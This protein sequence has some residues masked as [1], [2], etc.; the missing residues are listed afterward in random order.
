MNIYIIAGPPGV[1]K[2][3][4]GRELIPAEIPIVDHDLAAYQYKK[5]G[6]EDYS[7][8]ASTKANQFIQEH[9]ANKLDFALELNLGYQ[10]HYDYLESLVLSDKK[11]KVHLILFF[12]DD[13]NLCLLRAEVRYKNG[14]H[15]VTSSVINEMYRNTLPLFKNNTQL[16]SSIS[17]VSVSSTDIEEVTNI[18][19]PPWV[20]LNGLS[21]YMNFRNQ[22]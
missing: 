16:F 2:S 11:V 17:F 7:Q 9:I 18:R 6:F 19:V 14:G 21:K 22:A 12:T 3:T 1:G 4:Y 20:H 15:L 5:E 8:R 13:V 10:S